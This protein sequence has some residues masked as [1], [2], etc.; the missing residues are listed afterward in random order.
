MVPNK[1]FWCKIEQ[2]NAPRRIKKIEINTKFLSQE[3]GIP[4]LKESALF[5]TISL[6]LGSYKVERKTLVQR[7]LKKVHDRV[8]PALFVNGDIY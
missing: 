6:D 2:F 7:D 8:K 5:G 1:I 3:G 4:T